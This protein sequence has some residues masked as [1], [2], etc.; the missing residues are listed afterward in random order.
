[1]GCWELQGC[2]WATG[3]EHCCVH[4]L[5]ASTARCE[6][7]LWML[8]GMLRGGCRRQSVRSQGTNTMA[9]NACSTLACIVVRPTYR[10]RYIVI[11]KSHSVHGMCSHLILIALALVFG[12]CGFLQ[13]SMRDV[14]T[15]FVLSLVI[16][17]G[18][19]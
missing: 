9:S 17:K 19:S 16:L 4:V 7:L 18:L 10:C 1:L 8:S 5:I 15:A 3:L 2:R 6:K 12:I 11:P 13:Y 14:Q